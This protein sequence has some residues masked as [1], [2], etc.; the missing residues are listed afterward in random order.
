MHEPQGVL[1]LERPVDETLQPFQIPGIGIPD[2]VRRRPV[3]P[4][5]QIAAGTQDALAVA[6]G[7]GGGQKAGNGAVIRILEAMGNAQWVVLDE[8]GPLES[9]GRLVEPFPPLRKPYG[10]GSATK[11]RGSLWHWG[12]RIGGIRR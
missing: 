2:V 3:H 9:I 10:R 11:R 12:R 7:E 8:A 1:P 4:V 5:Q 6:P